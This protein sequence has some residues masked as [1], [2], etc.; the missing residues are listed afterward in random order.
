MVGRVEENSGVYGSSVLPTRFF[1]KTFLKDSLLILKILILI[2]NNSTIHHSNLTEFK[3]YN[4][5]SYP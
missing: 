3:F 1:C 2:G 4:E 5:I